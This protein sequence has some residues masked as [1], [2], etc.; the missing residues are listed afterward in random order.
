[1]KGIWNR[2]KN[3]GITQQI[4]IKFSIL[5]A[6]STTILTLFIM[7]NSKKNISD[8]ALEFMGNMTEQASNY[9][10]SEIE[11]NLQ[12][13]QSLAHS[14][15]LTNE[16]DFEVKMEELNANAEYYNHINIGLGNLD[17][18][19]IFNDGTTENF[20]GE[21][22]FEKAASGENA[23]K[24]P[25]YLSN[26]NQTVITYAIPVKSEYTGKVESIIIFNRPGDEISS[27]VR[28]IHFLETGEAFLIDDNGY[29][30]AD[31][32][33]SIVESHLNLTDLSSGIATESLAAI[34]TKMINGETGHGTYELYNNTRVVSYAPVGETGWSIA[35]Y[36]QKK[37][38]LASANV[39]RDISVVIGV[40]L[41]FISIAVGMKISR[42]LTKNLKDI[43]NKIK[44][45]GKGDFTVDIDD[46][47]IKREDEIGIIANACNEL[48]N[49]VGS[50][51][52]EIKNLGDSLKVN[53]SK[54]SNFSEELST[55]TN[56]ISL[57]ISE[58]SQGNTKQSE[59]ITNIALE[60]EDAT[61]KIDILGENTNVVQENTLQIEENARKSRIIVDDMSNLINKF[62][63]EFKV[64]KGNI[65]ELGDDMNKINSITS[66]INDI[67]EQTNLLALNAAIEAARAGE[68]GR[69]FAVVADEI[70]IL[71]EQS[72][73]NS[74]EINKIIAK[75]SNNT[76]NIVEKTRE[77]NNGLIEQSRQVENV[78]QAFDD[79]A[80]SV[81]NVI[82]ELRN[83]HKEFETVQNG[84][85]A[86]A[87]NIESLSA[88]SEQ[89]AAS[90][91]EILASSQELNESSNDL[92]SLAEK[93][94]TS[95]DVI[96][97]AMEQ[98]NI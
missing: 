32:D 94:D 36:V 22:F 55:S 61:K 76:E 40:L 80:L 43:A 34:A 88:I 21:D 14:K 98:F 92:V 89:V 54:I 3:P 49:S 10:N 71:A 44:D 29:V 91:Q 83:V 7:V 23:V 87:R 28:E 37:D 6:I 42:G 25:H 62:D 73:H 97:E 95:V 84:Q 17:G 70:R 30:I 60:T 96:M 78:K 11:K 66:I 12:I 59:E 63:G 27:L 33:S 4:A 72:K 64:F 2:I 24:E 81:E 39:I 1:M 53:S 47:I 85:K 8:S 67:S 68:M 9:V 45:M 77:I 75:S 41:F 58:V 65:E 90:S 56:N 16:N 26:V 20:K 79:I 93:L 5:M 38:L 50:M 69:G 18:E 46:K 57:S 82:P 51:I 15:T 48:K 13:G 35:I 52:V 86:V 31:N 74:E 19:F